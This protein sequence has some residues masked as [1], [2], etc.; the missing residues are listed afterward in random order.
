MN[1]PKPGLTLE[2]ALEQYFEAPAPRREFLLTLEQSLLSASPQ[3]P[4]RPHGWGRPLRSFPAYAIIA[5]VLTLL[6]ALL[7]VGPDRV[8]ASIAGLLR[9][10][11]GFGLVE[12]N[13]TIRVLAG[14][15]A[16]TRA[17][18]TLTV[19]QAVLT[20]QKTSISISLTGLPPEALPAWVVE[21][22]NRICIIATELRLPDGARFK[23]SGG[24]VSLHN[25]AFQYDFF[26]PG[27]PGTVHEATWFINC[28]PETLTGKAPENW[29]IQLRFVPAPPNFAQMPVIQMSSSPTATPTG[30]SPLA[31][32]TNPLSLKQVVKTQDGYIFIGSF[33]QALPV[34][35]SQLYPRILD[36]NGH[37]LG[38]T[39]P[40][41]IP[42]SPV[43]DE[44]IEWAYQ[45]REE[46]IAWPISIRYD[47][48]QVAC[49]DANAKLTFDTGPDP[50]NGQTWKIDQSFFSGPCKLKI[51]SVQLRNNG[52]FFRVSGIEKSG[53]IHLNIQGTAPIQTSQRNMPL[54]MEVGV[55]Y[56]GAPP[57]GLLTVSI[58]G[59][60]RWQGP[61]QVQLQNPATQVMP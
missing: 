57:K 53:Q 16:Q 30:R 2:N 4:S 1:D 34:P 45:V 21:E 40:K 51:D 13:T 38:Y 39:I 5:L 27:I 29:E 54:Y 10:I 18:V 55:I 47:E 12:E 15:V 44:S 8:L 60:A 22:K 42:L 52:Y 58:S 9:Y 14:P 11:P 61:W 28:L 59:N 33:R 6:A 7:L 17:G 48:V 31:A 56:E 23:G 41:D 25:N 35:I 19:Q 43:I 26:F 46:D 49:E 24:G 3:L 37:P 20:A 32:E 36:A 50:Q